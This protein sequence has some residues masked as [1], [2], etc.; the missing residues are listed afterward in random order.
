LALLRAA[1]A[2]TPGN[3]R[4]LIDDPL[5]FPLFLRHHAAIAKVRLLLSS[6]NPDPPFIC[7][8]LGDSGAGKSRFV[9][10]YCQPFFRF[11]SSDGWW[12]G[13]DGQD[14][15]YIDDMDGSSMQFR[16]LLQLLDSDCPRIKCKGGFVQPFLREVYI[17]TNVHPINWYSSKVT[18]RHQW[19]MSHPLCRRLEQFGELRFVPPFDPQNPVFPPTGVLSVGFR[20]P[21]YYHYG[22]KDADAGEAP[23][24]GRRAGMV[25]DLYGL[26]LSN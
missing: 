18:A 24:N 22:R 5:L 16:L 7:V 6:S 26:N 14:T 23:R 13:Y 12:D 2:P 15:V 4:A 11:A 20:N 17:T 9:K 1:I 3:D 8:L 19:D 10:E 21:A 25:E